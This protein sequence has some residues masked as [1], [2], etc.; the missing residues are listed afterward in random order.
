MNTIRGIKFW[1]RYWFHFRREEN[2]GT[3]YGCVRRGLRADAW[4]RE[5]DRTKY[6]W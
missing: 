4:N 2:L 6:D 3:L 5:R 1:T